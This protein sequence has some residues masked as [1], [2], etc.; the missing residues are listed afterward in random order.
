MSYSVLDSMET[1]GPKSIETHGSIQL[2][3]TSEL[4]NASWCGNSKAST[5]EETEHSTISEESKSAKEIPRGVQIL[6]G[7][8]PYTTL[9]K[10]DIRPISIANHC[11]IRKCISFMFIGNI[12][13][14]QENIFIF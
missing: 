9:C 4:F 1:L 14:H 2:S 10:G 7:N 6:Q 11:N 5:D 13:T 3:E 8:K 12:D